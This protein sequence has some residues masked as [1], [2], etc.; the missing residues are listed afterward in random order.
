MDEERLYDWSFKAYNDGSGPDCQSIEISVIAATEADALAEAK[1]VLPRD[2]HVLRWV[3][4][5]PAPRGG[6]ARLG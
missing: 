6:V 4:T 5:A 1:R 2:N 3:G